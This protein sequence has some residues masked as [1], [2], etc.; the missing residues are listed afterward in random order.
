MPRKKAAPRKEV[1]RV[2]GAERA[3]PSKREP[4][5]EEWHQL[6]ES[7]SEHEPEIQRTIQILMQNSAT[8]R[9]YLEYVTQYRP[10]LR[11]DEELA[12]IQLVTT[13]EALELLKQLLAEPRS[14]TDPDFFLWK[15]VW[16][17]P[18]DETVYDYEDIIVVAQAMENDS[19]DEI[20]RAR[21]RAVRESV[22][23][24]FEGE[25]YIKRKN[26]LMKPKR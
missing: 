13:Y 10:E 23:R 11:D 8:G 22:E 21:I 19:T 16:G 7:N 24:E 5:I 4:T 3:Q 17:K 26:S 12:F 20:E 25:R 1:D 9:A 18:A 15:D 2:Q 14:G 6:I